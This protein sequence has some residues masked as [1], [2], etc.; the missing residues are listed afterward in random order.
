LSEDWRGERAC[1]DRQEGCC[2]FR[3]SIATDFRHPSV[4]KRALLAV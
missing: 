3:D 1:E 4:I 2:R